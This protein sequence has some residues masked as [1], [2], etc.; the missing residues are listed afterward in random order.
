M[1]PL[2]S[3]PFPHTKILERKEILRIVSISP[4]AHTYIHM[5]LHSCMLTAPI[6]T[7]LAIAIHNVLLLTADDWQI[8]RDRGECIGVVYL[9]L[10]NAL[11]IG[12]QLAPY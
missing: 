4:R 7:N 3:I 6:Q 12:P 5:H 1:Q 9:D 11:I 8:A 2:S 10:S